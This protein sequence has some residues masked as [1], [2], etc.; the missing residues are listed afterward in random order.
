MTQQPVFLIVALVFMITL[1][2]LVVRLYSMTGNISSRTSEFAKMVASLR[3]SMSTMN[4]SINTLRDQAPDVGEYMSTF[5][6]HMGKLWFATQASNWGLAQYELGELTETM[7]AAEA[8]RAIK[9]N[10][11]TASVLQCVR[12]T[13]IPLLQQA[14]HDKRQ[15]KFYGANDQTLHIVVSKAFTI[16]AKEQ[17]KYDFVRELRNFRI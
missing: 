7:Q 10:V 12:G 14:L 11:N 5:Q 1:L 9:N 17:S 3:D 4:A 2:S 13:R 15:R 8:L 16:N 6:L